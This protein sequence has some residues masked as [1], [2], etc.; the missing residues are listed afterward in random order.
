MDS[1]VIDVAIGLVLVFA[2]TSLL[3]TALQEV[4]STASG[5]RGKVLRQAIASFVGDDEKFATALMGHPL[6]AALSPQKQEQ[7][8]SRRPSYVKA[9]AIVAALLGHLVDTHTAGIRPE[10]PLQ[11]IEAVR[12][13]LSGP[14]PAVAPQV[15]A[16]GLA[17]AGN[18]RPN[19]LFVRGLST[20]AMGVERDWPAFE[21]R[22]AAWYDAVGERSTGWFKRKTQAGV[23]VIGLLVAT[24]ANINPIVIASRLWTDE[25]LRQAVVAAASQASEAYARKQ[26]AGGDA[27]ASDRLL[28]DDTTLAA[29]DRQTGKTQPSSPGDAAAKVAAAE[30]ALKRV[31]KSLDDLPKSQG[32]FA[33]QLSPDALALDRA[34]EAWRAVGGGLQHPAAGTVQERARALL[35]KLPAEG[36]TKP[37]HDS[38]REIADVARAP[39]SSAVPAQSPRPSATGAS[40]PSRWNDVCKRPDGQSDD[41]W[42]KL[43]GTI[44]D[45]SSLKQLG[46]PIGWT[47]SARPTM[48]LDMCRDR[49][50]AEAADRRAGAR[51]C[52]TGNPPWG[53]YA[54]MPVGWL[55]VALACTLGA[56]FWFDALSKLI[57]LRGSGGRPEAAPPAGD[58]SKGSDKGLLAS[59]SSPAGPAGTGTATSDAPAMSDALND[60]ER[61]LSTAEVQRLQRGIGMPEVEVTGWFDGPTRRAIK[62]WQERM[63]LV[64]ATGELSEFQIRE[65]LAMRGALP[66]RVAGA[67]SDAPAAA[68]GQP[69]HDDEHAEGCEVPIEHV[70]DDE[71]L[72]ETR[73]GVAES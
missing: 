53:D 40:G 5:L 37:A 43:C 47:G 9:D 48:F 19:A 2:L 3:V 70:T 30:A 39:A 38:V 14:N 7:H 54:L 65:L 45:L 27:G 73:G 46:L 64:P 71:S 10:T 6:L 34:V 22:L 66:A 58:S 13:A 41:D 15:N 21:T 51:Q 31:W 33:A 67:A 29:T 36:A 68:T 50:D 57:R 25:P 59:S 56:P 63:K 49:A 23:F 11:L 18:A 61:A 28:N 8:D 35:S 72:P 16:T 52:G 62:A 4:Y 32:A 1:R 12:A 55:L 69:P 44:Q 26:T 24:I 42:R 17:D 60:A 20:L